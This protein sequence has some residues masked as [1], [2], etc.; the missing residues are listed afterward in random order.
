MSMNRKQFSLEPSIW[1]KSVDNFKIKFKEI[2]LENKLTITFST[3]LLWYQLHV[4]CSLLLFLHLSN[5]H[6][7]LNIY[8][9]PDTVVLEILIEQCG[10]QWTKQSSLSL[11]SLHSGIG[12]E[13]WAY[14][15]SKFCRLQ[16]V[17]SVIG[18]EQGKD[19]GAKW[20]DGVANLKQC[21]NSGPLWEGDIWEKEVMAGARLL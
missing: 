9:I 18:E 6:L 10:S 13:I 4:L 5:T 16:M 1:A 3:E 21:G 7:L 20:W 2:W 8:Y 11:R 17:I 15:I 12:R 14:C 19:D